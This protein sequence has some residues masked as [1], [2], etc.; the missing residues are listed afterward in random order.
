V[1]GARAGI[2]R[3]ER[4]NGHHGKGDVALRSGHGLS[5]DDDPVGGGIGSLRP[6]EDDAS[7]RRFE[8]P[9][10]HGRAAGLIGAHRV[11]GV[12]SALTGPACIA[13][14]GGTIAT[15]RGRGAR[16][17]GPHRVPGV[18]PALTGPA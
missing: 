1:D 4:L 16:W 2:R 6:F 3:G 11:P 13:D 12:A 5:I 10:R 8:D 7:A 9:T 14:A 18:A 15:T 17:V